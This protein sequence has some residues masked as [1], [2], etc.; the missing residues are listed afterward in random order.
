MKQDKRPASFLG[1]YMIK[2]YYQSLNSLKY[3]LIL[4][5]LTF[6]IFALIYIRHQ[7]NKNQL[8]IYIYILVALL[9]IVVFFY[10]KSKLYIY[11]QLKKIKNIEEYCKGGM[12]DKSWVL[13]ERLLAYDRGKIKEI[14]LM[15][16]KTFEVQEK[17][18]GQLL[19]KLNDDVTL[20]CK[21]KTEAKRLLA[22]LL[23]NN[24]HLVYH[25]LIPEGNG[26]ISSLGG[27]DE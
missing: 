9:A 13:K 11:L 19:I 1:G 22:I 6:L 26:L 25:N 17:K 23:R 20:S 8:S 16:V 21:D 2:R 4:P 24:N 10:Y 5:F 18:Y 7:K 3:S 14:F 15:N 27:K 12:I